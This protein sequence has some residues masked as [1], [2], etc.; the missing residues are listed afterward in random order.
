[1][2]RIIFVLV[3]LL[4]TAAC[5]VPSLD[6]VLSDKRTEYEKSES[7]PPL[8]VPPDLSATEES[9]AMAIPGETTTTTLKDYQ[10]RKNS[11]QPPAAERATPQVTNT[12]TASTA[13]TS[14]PVAATAEQGPFVVVK[15]DKNSVWNRLRSFITG[16][17]YLLELDD[18]E[19]GYIETDW[20]SPVTE[21]GSTFRNKFKIFTDEGAGQGMTVLYIE[22]ERQEQV[23]QNSGNIIWTDRSKSSDAE[24][25]LAGEMNLFF[26]GRQRQDIP[27]QPA[28][29]QIAFN[30]TAPVSR[31]E[32]L[33][34]GEKPTAEIQD[35][36]NNKILLAIPAEYTL[37][38][39][40]TEMAL[41]L[42]G[43]VIRSKDQEQGLYLITYVGEEDQGGWLKKLK[44]WGSDK[45]EGVPYQIA[46]TG[47][48]NKTE[49]VLLK[50]NGDW[51][52]GKAAEEILSMIRTQY[53]RL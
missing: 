14:A 1:M 34:P 27:Q 26:N 53:N 48:G 49:L 10:N 30:N 22:N 32:N 40:R 6:E 4:L 20:S 35:I 29:S 17:G 11:N 28:Q 15:G 7:L 50:E 25:I 3:L 8:E 24:R 36:G 2:N 18:L 47:V 39:R 12:H 37:A 43:L 33:V 52:E 16:K 21:N 19:L 41:N 9:D 42:A 31:Q 46:L 38:W 51:E 23:A 5:S 13:T 44:F 45:G